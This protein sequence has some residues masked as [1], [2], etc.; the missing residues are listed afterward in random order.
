[1]VAEYR[2]PANTTSWSITRKPIIPVD[3][4]KFK[5]V[6]LYNKKTNGLLT[7]LDYIDPIQGKIAGPAEQEIS[8]KTSY[9]PAKYS[10]STDATITADT[11]DYTSNEWIGKLWWDIDSAKFINYHQGDI[12]ESTAN[13]NTLFAG[14]NAK[15]HEW[16]ESTLLPSEWDAQSSTADGV[17][18]GISG[19]SLYLSLIHI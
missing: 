13:F 18:N 14:T 6:Y 9:D 16:V 4:S 17:E 5:G 10:T 2:K 19:T 15:V 8:F 12:S 7:Y 11:L 1:M 3:T